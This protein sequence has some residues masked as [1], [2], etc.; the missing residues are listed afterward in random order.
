MISII[1]KLYNL[2]RYYYISDISVSVREDNHGDQANIR[3]NGHI[4]YDGW[5]TIRSSRDSF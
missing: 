4:Y 3:G 2:G 5:S 1:N